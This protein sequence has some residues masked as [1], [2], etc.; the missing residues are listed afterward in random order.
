MYVLSS[1]DW[2]TESQLYMVF[3]AV[4]VHYSSEIVCFPFVVNWPLMAVADSVT[5]QFIWTK[6]EILP[7]K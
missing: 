5:I 7:A 3:V 4:I 1:S 6:V 2:K